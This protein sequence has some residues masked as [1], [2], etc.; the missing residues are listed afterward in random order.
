MISK[1]LAGLGLGALFGLGFWYLGELQGQSYADALSTYVAPFGTVF[2]HMLK[3]V[4]VPIVFFTL[5]LGA[6]KLPIAHLGSIG[7]KLLALYL[8]TSFLATAVG[9]GVAFVINPGSENASQWQKLAAT[10]SPNPEIA[11]GAVSPSVTSIILGMFDNPFASLAQANFLGLIVFAILL[12]LALSACQDESDNAHIKTILSG[13]T[14]LNDALYRIVGWVMS[15]APIGVFALSVVNFG[16]Y[17]PSILGPYLK[18]VLGIVV[19]ILIMIFVIYGLLIKITTGESPITF[20]RACK[21]PMLTAFA[22]RSSAAALPISMK[23]ATGQLGVP[24]HIASFALPLG[25]TINMDGVCVHLPMF[26]IL[27]TNLFGIQL[28]SGDLALL[29]LT[30]VLAAIGTGGVPGGSLMLLFLVLGALGLPE[31]H[32]AAV[33]SLALGVNPVLD[34]FETMNNVTGDLM[35][36]KVVSPRQSAPNS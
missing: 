15:Y 3:M 9:M 12:G 27:T 30:T 14:G 2:V 1:M 26:A 17:G 5:T 23:A 25:A 8:L 28:G 33:I 6:S 16:V 19:G 13:L 18:V 11:A 31:A 29:V 24:Q 32:I 7:A 22:T 34:M 35:C 36:A 20:F 4:V 21:E 10:V